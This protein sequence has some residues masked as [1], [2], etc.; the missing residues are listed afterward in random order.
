[1]LI[2]DKGSIELGRMCFHVGNRNILQGLSSRAAE[3]IMIQ[4]P[5]KGKSSQPTVMLE[6]KDLQNIEAPIS[7]KDKAIH[8]TK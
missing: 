1:M 8:T 7:L 4:C 3:I 6:S 2:S 5:R